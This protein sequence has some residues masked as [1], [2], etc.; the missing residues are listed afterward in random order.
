MPNENQPQK[1]LTMDDLVGKE[2]LDK[3][4]ELENAEVNAALSLMALENEK[5]KLLAVSRRVEDERRR[6]FEKLL[7][8]RGLSPNVPATIDSTTGRM[9]L[10]RPHTPSSQEAPLPAQEASTNGQA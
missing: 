7:I 6:L 1:R 4:S 2:A 10:V 3:L 9:S 5:V 8:E